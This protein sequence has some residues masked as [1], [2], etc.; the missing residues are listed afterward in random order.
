MA[1]RLAAA[2]TKETRLLLRDKEA[3]LIL[4]VMPMTFVLILSLAMQD[5]FQERAGARFPLLIVNQ[6]DGHVASEVIKVFRRNDHFR[7]HVIAAPD[8]I[9]DEAALRTDLR[10][11]R[12]K[13]AIL[14][15]EATTANARRRLQQHLGSHRHASATDPVTLQFISDPT[16][17]GDQRALVQAALNRALQGVELQMLAQQFAQLRAAAPATAPEQPAA[18]R[19]F[20]EVVDASARPDAALPTSV[21]QNTPAWALLAMFFLVVPLSVALIKE[22][23]L[24]SLIRL[25]SMGASAS[26]LF[27]GKI[28]PYFVINQL[29]LVLILLEGV[30]LLPYFGGDALGLG[31][32]PGAIAML[33]ASASLAAIGF[34]LL[35]ASVARTPEQATT[36]GAT[37]VLILAAIGGILVPKIVMPP[38]MQRLADVSPLS[39]GLEGFLDIFVR[40]GDIYSVVPEALGLAAFATVCFVIAL[41]RL[42]RRMSGMQ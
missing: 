35:I 40:A 7:T 25:Q 3:L 33:S 19:V 42:R 6:D 31:D 29:Q 23:Q 21:Q 17:R 12:Y 4:F 13:F 9:P 1:A 38:A 20:A 11:G 15:P 32:A 30:Y 34:G 2:V 24:G 28:V 8:P 41:W 18:T 22:Q 5:T 10:S 27:A 16:V 39:W 14:I 37:S 36:F 26:V